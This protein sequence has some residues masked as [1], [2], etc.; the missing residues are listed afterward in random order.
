MIAANRHN[1][2]IELNR[3]FQELRKN[4]QESDETDFG[5]APGFGKSLHWDDLAK[6]YRV[7]I[8][9]EAGS[10][11]STEIHQIAQSLRKQNKQ[12]FFLR[13]ENISE[14]F[15]VAFEVG[16]HEEFRRWL[17][18]DEEG[19]LL[20]DSVDE[21]R[22]RHPGDFQLAIRKLSTEI[23]SALERVH[24]VITG[25]TSAWRPKTDL[26]LCNNHLPYVHTASERG[27]HGE[28]CEA[29]DEH[30]KVKTKGNKRTKKVF[31]IVT[32]EDLTDKQIAVFAKAQGIN[33]SNK[34]LDAVDR[35]DAW[36]FTSRPQDLEELIDFWSDQGHIG[37]GLEIM[38]NSIERRLDERDQDRSESYPLSS[39]RARQGAKILAAATTLTTD[40]TIGVPDGANNTQGIAVETILQDWD[41]KNFPALLSRP[42]FDQAI[43]STVRFHHR[44]VREYLTAEWFADL[45]KHETSRRSIES[46]FFRNLY[47][48]E[49]VVPTLR[50]ILPWLVHF[51]EKIR[52]RVYELSPEIFFEGGDPSQLPLEIRRQILR[53]VCEQ[54]ARDDT[55]WPSH[56]RSVVQR[57]AKPDLADDVCELISKYS[58]NDYL[59]QFLLYM[60]WVG[61]LEDLKQEVME[62]A[63]TPTA[64]KNVRSTA[65]RAIYAIGSD[66]DRE[67]VRQS[68]LEETPVLQREWLTDLIEGV[69]PSE[70]TISWLLACLEKSEFNEGYR[71]DHLAHGVT[72]FVQSADV[73]LLPGLI[74]GF[75]GFLNLPPMIERH[76]CEVSEKYQGLL[77]PASK[78]VGRLIV[79][80][81]PASLEPDSLDVLDK[82]VMGHEYLGYDVGNVLSEFSELVPAWPTL[83]RA[84]F[85]FGIGR[86][87]K[88]ISKKDNNR[89]TNYWQAPVLHSFWRFEVDDFE[90]VVDEISGRDFID[91]KLVALSLAFNLYVKAKRP[92]AWREKLKKLV[93]EIENTELS[94]RLKTYLTHPPQSEEERRI[95]RQ[96]ANWKKQDKT[97]RKK[98]EK[99]HTLNK[100]R[101]EDNLESTR[102]KLR[103]NP[104]VMTR[105]MYYLLEQTR[106][107]ESSTE[108]DA[109]RNWER[110]I[111]VYGEDIAHFY[112]EAAISFWRYYKPK[113]RSEGASSTNIHYDIS[114][115]LTGLEI[116]AYED[117]NWIEH[118]NPVE[119]ELACR[120]A[121][122]EL[123]GFPVWFQ[124][125]FDAHPESVCKFLMQEI[126]YELSVENSEKETNYILGPVS[127]TGQWGWNKL[128]P[129]IYEL[130]EKEPGNL[131]NLS[132]LLKIVQGSDLPD[133]L[134]EKLASEKCRTQ[135]E[136]QR[137][138]HW[139]AVWTGVSPETAIASLQ[140][141]LS[142]IDDVHEQTTFAMIFVTCLVG[143]RLSGRA[144]TRRE[145]K[146]PGHLKSLYLLMHQYIRA[147]EDID[148]SGSGVYSPD[149]RDEAQDA[150]DRLFNLLNQTPGR[151]A[152]SALDELSRFHPNARTCKWIKLQAKKR[153]ELDSDMEPWAPEDVREFN[154]EMERTPKSHK[155]LAELAGLRLLDLKYDIEQ[156]DGSFAVTL[157]KII[158]ETEMRNFI[159]RELR[160]KANGRYSIPQ[161]EELADAKKPDL[162]FHGM[163]FDGPVPV[164]LKLA[165]NCT[166]PELFERLENQLC[167]SYLRD[168]RSSRGIFLLVYRG[169]KTTWEMS[170]G[171]RV[172][173]S[174]LV[175][176]IQRHWQ[177][178][179][180]KFP[181]VEDIKVVGIDLMRRL[182]P[183]TC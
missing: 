179:S 146:N 3:T 100:K 67:I 97:R 148:R 153:A 181:R 37:T 163:G 144:F 60:V 110:L 10:G 41:P 66:E 129:G 56:D 118:L 156:G 59:T 168:A 62:H 76:L 71:F 183:Q 87:R 63:L 105:S 9:S 31:K 20:L 69:K 83:N 12:A 134:I 32:L 2:F 119:V 74:T 108:Q 164:E 102:K 48:T 86:A 150:R 176:T 85:W 47:G 112:K 139:F 127:R 73:E 94:D 178:I 167:G 77:G 172:V 82:L 122:Y 165:D 17:E 88:A 64:E 1:K 138:G 116:E 149:L 54:I 19:W 22:L 143:G 51:D 75:N 175:Y 158:K 93:R 152:Y 124:C 5:R 180:P 55:S 96:E 7:I 157:Q 39:D 65:F 80:R 28:N 29:P 61:Q 151:E 8:L 182:T 13:L 4:A 44:T 126:R 45:L 18:A 121:T 34:F 89:L 95:K 169:S 16:T 104:G 107:M 141:R 147:D 6:E 136:L 131:S 133:E 98:E 114:I 159:G 49:V 57:F 160:E 90:Y 142:E 68:F 40:Q 106:I 78:A 38:R 170:D 21:A 42:V 135:T 25:R 161:E 91:D 103:E 23:E 128:A 81:H 70:E 117:N 155:E 154:D 53:D 99:I 26:E 130:L 92:R 171:K 30:D 109:K 125:L 162:R 113:F 137:Q 174:E 140:K 46:L 101:L 27:R 111:P 14:N 36:P 24:I 120:Y 173:F 72:D 84:L 33:D 166:G 50:P 177:T 58:D 35:A 52:V 11:K 132:K 115:G 15:N 43:Y 123:N 145:F 79:E